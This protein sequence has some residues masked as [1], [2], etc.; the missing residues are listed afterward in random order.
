MIYRRL[1]PEEPLSQGDILDGCP[2]FRLAQDEG[3]VDLNAEPTRWPAR[4]IIL[5]QACDLANAKTTQA[6]VAI[7]HAA[8]DLADRQILNA[9]LIRDKVRRHQVFGWYFLPEF[10]EANFPESIVDLRNLYT[11]PRAVLEA[12]CQQGTRRCRLETP[13]REHL[14]QH[15]ANTYA[16]IGLPEP[17]ETNP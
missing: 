5:T 3:P 15:F 4:V 6:V 14:A 9:A 13:Y 8:Q 2:I 12:L 16:R 11:I 17:Y 7:V 1:G 10:L